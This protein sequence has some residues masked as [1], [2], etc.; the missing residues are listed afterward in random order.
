MHTTRLS[1]FKFISIYYGHHAVKLLKLWIGYRRKIIRNSLQH[2]RFLKQC[3]SNN[4]TPQHLNTISNWRIKLHNHRSNHKFSQCKK[5]MIKKV[6]H[7][8]LNDAYRQT[9]FY[10]R[11]LFHVV[12]DFIA[13]C[14]QRFSMIFF[15]HRKNLVMSCS[16]KK[17][18]D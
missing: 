18:R 8:K 3:A 5:L 16:K 15:I 6:L 12:S 11:S 7:L 17:E 14:L 9:D 2:I 1:F 10:R 13:V 4:I